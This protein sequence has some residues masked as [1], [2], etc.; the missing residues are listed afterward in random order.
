MAMI[1]TSTMTA[2]CTIRLLQ[3]PTLSSTL[4]RSQCS[5]DEPPSRLCPWRRWWCGWWWWWWPHREQWSWRRCRLSRS[6]ESLVAFGVGLVPFDLSSVLRVRH[7]KIL[8]FN[9]GLAVSWPIPKLWCLNNKTRNTDS[10]FNIGVARI[11]SGV[12]FFIQKVDDL[13]LVV[14]LKRRFNILQSNPPNK[15]CSKNWLFLRLGVHFVSWG[16]T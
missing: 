6:L 16:C 15:K 12:H 1:S 11:L 8:D 4:Q 13:F 3:T 9:S 5:H 14:A 10:L 7:Q 2:I